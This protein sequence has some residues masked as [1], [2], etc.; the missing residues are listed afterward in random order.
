MYEVK[1]LYNFDNEY[2]GVG[3][4]KNFDI[5]YGYR[6]GK[7][8]YLADKWEGQFYNTRLKGKAIK[9]KETHSFQLIVNSP[10]EL[11]NM[12]FTLWGFPSKFNGRQWAIK[13]NS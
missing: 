4:E 9:T 5:Y 3:R 2:L 12:N 11:Y 6:I 10:E 13:R 1:E 7:K 8:I